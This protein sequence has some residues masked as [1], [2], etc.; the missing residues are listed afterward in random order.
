VPGVDR[1]GVLESSRAPRIKDPEK[2]PGRLKVALLNLQASER[3]EVLEA[4][5]GVVPGLSWR[6]ECLRRSGKRHASR[7]RKGAGTL[8]GGVRNADKP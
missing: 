5:R 6:A 4:L 2:A 7:T 3:S 8:E 1:S